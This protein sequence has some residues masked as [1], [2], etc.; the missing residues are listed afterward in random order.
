[1]F[2][3]LFHFHFFIFI[4]SFSFFR[5]RLR[6]RFR[7]QCHCHC[8]FIKLIFNELSSSLSLGDEGTG[9][10]LRVPFVFLQHFSAR[11]W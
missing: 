5:F 1:M 7:C 3:F 2:I 4:F 9:L 6:F 11:Q 8:R 10:V